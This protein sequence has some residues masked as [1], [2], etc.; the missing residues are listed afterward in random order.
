VQ[1]MRKVLS[2]VWQALFGDPVRAFG[3]VSLGLLLALAIAPA[4]EHFSQWHSYQRHYLALIHDR[5]DAVSLR[6]RFRPG[7]HQ[8]WL[9]ELGVVDRCTT[10]HL[11]LNEA[12]LGDVGQQP[13]RKHPVIPHSLDGFG[14]VICHGGQGPATTVA[15][16]HHSERAG[17]EPILPARYIESGC[18][19][20]HQN[21]LP[22]TPQLNLGRTMLTRYGCVHCHA[23]TRP[24]GTKVAATDH[25][26]SL[27]HIADKTTREWIY[28]WLKDPQAYAAS[29]T[30]PNYKLSDVDASDISAY[31]VSTSTQQAGDTAAATVQP[32]AKADPSAGPS[33]YGESFCSSCHA[34]QNAAGNLVG[35]DVGPELTRL[36][37]KVKPEW[38]T[39]WLQNPRVYDATTP[40]PHYRFTAQQIATLTE[41][42]HGKADSDFGS[43]VH[44]DAANAKQIAHGRKLI[45]ELGCSACHDINGV[46]KPENFAPELS[47]IGSKP[48]AQIVFLPGMEHSLPSYIAAK[49][50]Q[51]RAFG[52]SVKMPQFALTASQT[53]AL[54]T[55]LLALTNRGRS[56]PDNLRVAAIEETNYQ[57]AGHAGKLM[58]ELVCTSCHRINGR[59]GDMAPDLT[60]EGSAVQRQWLIDF[61]HNPNTLRPS[62]IRRMPRFNLSDSDNKE[63]T[64]YILAVYQSP[65]IDA[66]LAPAAPNL[67]ATVEHGRQLFYSKYACQSCH[68]VDSKTD[69]GYVGP[70]LTQVGSRLTSAWVYS[71]LRNPQALRPGTT[72]PNQNL[73]DDDARAL[74][75]FLLSLKGPSGR[76]A[77]R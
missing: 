11:G 20:C 57:P 70:T 72:E 31:L 47:A 61:L 9:P 56:M 19:Q 7:I 66:D 17:E 76:G 40:M 29:T 46:Q 75:A 59:G 26:P 67:P 63:L 54:T 39:A 23:I 58:T 42:L 27:V 34:V 28:S 71:W 24:D 25:P 74:T 36:G 45:V 21:A 69:K 16:A 1:L 49:I 12:S 35:G 48:L 51:P 44:L 10:C 32:A 77:K 13:F 5:G 37:N 15:E 43:G 22:G 41:Y 50:R 73:S 14:C 65:S 18:G 30:M 38:L 68:I 3:V 64:D 2:S 62:L 8:I 33:L 60:W 4:K 53:D 6:R 52:A 55:A